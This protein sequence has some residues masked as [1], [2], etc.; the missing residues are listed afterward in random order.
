[1]RKS[2]SFKLNFLPSVADLIFCVILFS[3]FFSSTPKLLGDGD[4]GYHIRAGQYIIR[5]LSIPKLDIFSFRTP[6]LPWTA[7]EWLSEVIMAAVHDLSGLTGIVAFFALLLAGSTAL[8][9]R[10]LRSYGTDLL[11]ATA[12]TMLAFTASQIHWLARPH[13]FSLLLMITWHYLLESWQRGGPNRLYLLPALML[14]WV[15]LHGGFVGGF[16]LLGAYL[17]GNLAS[18]LAL[19]TA[20]RAACWKKLRVLGL[21][22]GACLIACLCNPNGYQILLFPFQLVSDRFVMDH[23]TEFLSPNFHEFLPFKYMLLLL[24]AIFAVSK[25]AVEPTELVLILIFTNMALYAGR[26]IPLFALIVAPILTRP[27]DQPRSP[28]G[29]VAEFC[30]KRSDNMARMDAGATSYLWPAAAVLVV[31]LAAG[32]GRVHHSFDAKTKPVAAA[33]FMM[34]ERIAG[35]M[36][37]N[38]EF[39]DYIVYRCYPDYKVFIDGRL[40]MYGAKNMKE[41][42]E[43]ASFEQGWEAILDKYHITWI[44]YDSRSSLSRLLATHNNWKLIYSDQVANIFVKNIPANQYLIERY[45]GVKPVIVE[46]KEEGSFAAAP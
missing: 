23:V 36:F 26:Y 2:Y 27:S 10:I 21:T 40:D 1:V 9:F 41:Y 37:N 32:S 18:L 20:A 45:R 42:L 17:V 24:I 44:V 28:G 13:V 8:L 15:N 3:L 43:V 38:D 5:T 29:R 16:I 46:D 4:T 6:T 12:I 19:P 22:V 25:R 34:K 30:R 39:G 35:N 14:L 11:L 7:H 31:A 33:E